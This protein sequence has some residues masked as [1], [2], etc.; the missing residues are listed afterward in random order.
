MLLAGVVK[1]RRLP[2]NAVIKVESVNSNDVSIMQ[3][4]TDNSGNVFPM[5]SS[6]ST[7]SRLQP[8]PVLTSLPM[9]IPSVGYHCEHNSDMTECKRNVGQS[10]VCVFM[11]PSVRTDF[12]QD[13]NVE[14][15]R[16][17]NIIGV[18]SLRQL[19]ID[20]YPI[21]AEEPSII[22]GQS[23]STGPGIQTTL[24]PYFAGLP[25]LRK[26]KQDGQ[27]QSSM[28]LG[29]EVALDQ[30]IAGLSFLEKP[31]RERQEDC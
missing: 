21:P 23:C 24:D 8:Q 31:K 10:D 6:S 4:N 18:P 3:K 19:K 28:E 13:K 1:K 11:N 27:D 20:E 5:S 12:I 22:F 14:G 7:D 17:S 2:F 29:N 25:F 30:N 16:S 26:L 9:K 15:E